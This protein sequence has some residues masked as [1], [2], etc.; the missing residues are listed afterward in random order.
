MCRDPSAN[1]IDLLMDLRQLR[2]LDAVA[3]ARSFTAAALELHLAQSALSQQV[4]KLERE[5][6]VELLR[7]TTRRVEVTEAGQVVLA[8]ARRARAGAHAIREGLHAPRGP[9]RGPPR[10]RRVAPPP[11]PPPPAPVAALPPPPPGRRP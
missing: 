3:R 4:A 10:V 1:A 8:R 11:R 9:V 5:L 2:A 6:G 7:R